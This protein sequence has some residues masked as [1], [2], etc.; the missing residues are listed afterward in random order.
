MADKDYYS[1]LGVSRDAGADEVK[2]AYRKLALKYHPDR[3][4]GNKEAE[5]KFKEISE[6]YEVLSDSQKR[7]AY[8]QFGRAGVYGER[9]GFSGMRGAG[10]EDLFGDIFGDLFGGTR[11]QRRPTRRRG[12]QG[13][14]L[15]FDIT[16]S[17]EESA[18]GKKTRIDLPKEVSC[19]HCA[20]SGAKPGT[21]PT[22]CVQCQGTGEVRFSQGF[23]SISRTCDRCQGEGETITTPCSMCHGRGTVRH[24]K[25]VEVNIP[26]GI[27]TGQSLRLSGEGNAG[28][29]GG[30]PG[31]LYLVVRVESHPFFTRENN[32]VVCEV[33]I[34]FTQ[35]ALGTQVEVPTLYG[36]V[37]M[38]VPPGTQWGKIFRLK[39]KGFPDIRGYGHG[40]QLTKIIIETPMKLSKEQKEILNK[41]ASITGDSVQPTR[42]SFLDKMKE[43]FG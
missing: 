27:D 14:D 12:I 6:S 36:K 43:L 17:F 32:D 13:G 21:K 35:A 7:Q 39:S 42:R 38:K 29:Q 15:R 4:P 33:P 25:T 16:I 37:E 20:G 24:T 40:D 8:D 19:S 30:P 41:F 9:P 10:F 31:D 11:R 22:R 34:T 26:A 23:F 28:I 1:I 5:E 18:F 3:N 2:K